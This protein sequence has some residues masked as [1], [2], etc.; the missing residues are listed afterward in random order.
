MDIFRPDKQG[1]NIFR[2]R[3]GN[4][5]NLWFNIGAIILVLRR[6]KSVQAQGVCVYRWSIAEKLKN[7]GGKT[8]GWP[9]CGK[10]N[11]ER[12]HFRF[13]WLHDRRWHLYCGGR[14]AE[15]MRRADRRF[16]E[17]LQESI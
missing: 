16:A 8:A 10:R 11:V 13:R 3:A 15:R 4:I 2:L 9:L 7:L 14:I 6:R 17:A 5:R 12:F 1:R